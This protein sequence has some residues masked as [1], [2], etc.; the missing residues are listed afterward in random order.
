MKIT[1]RSGLMM[2]AFLAL[3]M[4]GGAFLGGC[5]T[6]AP[7]K[8]KALVPTDRGTVTFMG[9]YEFIAPVG[10]P[11]YGTWRAG[12]LSWGSGRWKRGNFPARPLSSM[13]M[14]P[15]AVLRT[16]T[17]GPSNT[18]PGSFSTAG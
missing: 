7:E 2:G 12:I 9:K 10:W 3:L 17:G 4:A 18:A 8:P 5:A 1:M 14:S 13:M 6:L 15:S 16:W 11:L